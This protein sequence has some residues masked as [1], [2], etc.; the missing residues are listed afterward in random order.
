MTSNSLQAKSS[1]PAS[2]GI[3]AT[4]FIPTYYGED[5]L[6]ELFQAIYNQKTDFEFE[7]LV[8]DTSSKDR[9]PEII[10]EW[11]PRF[12]HFRYETITKPEFS[13]GRVRQQAAQ[14]AQGE[15][16]VYLTQDA[17]PAHNRWLY[18][19]IQ[20]MERFPQVAGVM[21]KQD[22]R[23]NALPLL[24]EEIIRTFRQFGPDFGT[25]LFYKDSFIDSQQ[26]FDL[27]TFYS[28]VNSAARRSVLLGDIPYQD[29]PYAE[30]QKLGE[31]IV[32]HGYVKAYAP[33][34][35]VW[36]TNEIKLRD[37]KKRMFDE[38]VGVRRIGKTMDPISVPFVIKQLIRALT[39]GSLFILRDHQYSWKRK[40]YWLALNP[41][42]VLEKWKGVRAGIAVG[43]DDDAAIERNSL[44]RQNVR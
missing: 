29:V 4:V 35:N 34:A 42:F 17:T 15:Y 43:L 39:L 3:K 2:N 7:V 36:H 18:E 23:P 24:K 25:T 11:K 8:I 22:P 5:N 26:I 13:H 27:V 6:E 14:L 44:E 10:R 32:N 31:D 12:Q 9:T 28:D 40:L 21:G 41:L 33:R 20:P 19:I 1:S 30:D 37:Y 38:I 16:V